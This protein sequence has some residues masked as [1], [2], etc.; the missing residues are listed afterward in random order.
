[1]SS[2]AEWVVG[3]F[4]GNMGLGIAGEVAEVKESSLVLASGDELVAAGCVP[5]TKGVA[6]YHVFAVAIVRSVTMNLAKKAAMDGLDADW[7]KAII[8]GVLM[9][10]SALLG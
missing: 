4:A 8:K 9:R 10:Q 7:G 5:V 3:S 1:M 6:D 2:A